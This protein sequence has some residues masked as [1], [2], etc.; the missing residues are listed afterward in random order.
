[1]ELEND[2]DNEARNSASI[3]KNVRAAEKRVKD[4]EF[5]IEDERKNRERAE[6]AADKL[7][8]RCK[9]MRMQMEDMV[10]VFSRSFPFYAFRVI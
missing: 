1:M 4:A 7:N 3:A 8:A 2:L 5:A 9:K 6:D 10:R